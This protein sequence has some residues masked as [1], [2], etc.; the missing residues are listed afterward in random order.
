ML[1]HEIFVEI[2]MS[3]PKNLFKGDHP[4]LQFQ[5][6][7]WFGLVAKEIRGGELQSDYITLMNVSGGGSQEPRSASLWIPPIDTDISS[8]FPVSSYALTRTGF[9][10][11]W[12][13][14]QLKVTSSG[15]PTVSNFYLWLFWR[16]LG[17]C[18]MRFLSPFLVPLLNYAADIQCDCITCNFCLTCQTYFR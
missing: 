11:V 16:L 12:H 9:S 15:Y 18:L 5:R 13:Q 4:Q 14:M 17:R 10:P 1:L 3:S 7:G 6:G 8:Y 2:L